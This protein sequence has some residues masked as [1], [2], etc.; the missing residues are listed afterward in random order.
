MEKWAAPAI[1]TLLFLGVVETPLWWE[2]S[3][4]RMRFVHQWTGATASS[5]PQE[6]SLNDSLVISPDSLLCR[7]LPGW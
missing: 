2:P 3:C 5:V 4:K 7:F 1:W 6:A